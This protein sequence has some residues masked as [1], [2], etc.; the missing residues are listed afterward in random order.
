MSGEAS[1]PAEGPERERSIGKLLR[2]AREEMGL[3]RDQLA[4]ELKIPVRLL[5]SVESDEW[6]AV[7]PGRERPLARQLAARLHMDLDHHPDALGLVPG[8]ATEAPSDPKLE[9]LERAAMV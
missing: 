2:E 1:R 3:S 8:T 9:R 7:P 4:S 6:D 5:T